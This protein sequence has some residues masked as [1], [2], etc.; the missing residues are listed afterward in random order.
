MKNKT[1]FKVFFL[2]QHTNNSLKNIV[3]PREKVFTA[4]TKIPQSHRSAKTAHCAMWTALR[5]QHHQHHNH[6]NPS[7]GNLL[8]ATSFVG[9][10]INVR[11]E[12]DVKNSQW[13]VIP[14]GMKGFH[15]LCS[16][17]VPLNCWFQKAILSYFIFS[18]MFTKTG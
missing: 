17:C 3:F 14:P 16:P 9:E 4:I 15:N 13:D 2:K 11:F 10:R 18:G 1:S 5:H 7:L 8:S 12:E 6:H